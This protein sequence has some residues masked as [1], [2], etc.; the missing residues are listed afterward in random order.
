MKATIRLIDGEKCSKFVLDYRA[1]NG[2]RQRRTFDTRAE[3]DAAYADL[4]AQEALGGAVWLNLGARGRAEVLL[5]VKE[6]QE[7]GVSVRDL[8]DFW[9]KSR[10]SFHNGQPVTIKQLVIETIQTAKTTNCRQRYIDSLNQVLFKFAEGREQLAISAVSLGDIELWLASQKGRRGGKASPSSLVGYRARLCAMYAEAVRRRYIMPDE[11]PMT[12]VLVPKVDNGIPPFLKPKEAHDLLW[13]CR[14][15]DLRFLPY[16]VLGM[17]AGIRPEELEKLHWRSIDLDR[18]TITIEELVSKTRQ[19]R[20]IEIKD[21]PGLKEWLDECLRNSA[22]DTMGHIVPLDGDRRDQLVL[23]QV[24]RW[25][26]RHRRKIY[27]RAGVKPEQDILRK[28]AATYLMVQ[29][30]NENKVSLIL[31]NSPKILFKHYRGLVRR[32]D[33]EAFW[34]NT[35]ANVK[36]DPIALPKGGKLP[37]DGEYGKT[38]PGK[39]IP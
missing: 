13:V 19:R 26:R 37:G 35:P 27:E 22:I 6:C 34:R 32:E 23:E 12:R 21:V 33:N 39:L 11:N 29:H 30:E 24:S 31:G 25:V 9:K 2:K 28:T 14:V 3:V 17:F 1:P 8:L 4:Q 10:N 15:T 18:Q 20:I 5:A 16:L 7:L 38:K 36:T